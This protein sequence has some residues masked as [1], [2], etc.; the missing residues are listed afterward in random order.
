MES[1]YRPTCAEIS[2]DALEYNITQFRNHLPAGMKLLTCV[3]A[4]AYGHGAV[5]I[6]KQVTA[7]GV[8]YLAVA[9]LDEAL[10]LRRAGIET[11]VLIL[12]YTPPSGIAAAAEYGITLNL[13]SEEMLEAIQAYAQEHP[14]QSVKAHIKIDTGMGRV[15][16][17]FGQEAIAFIEHALQVPGLEIEGLFTHFASSD[18]ADKT[19]MMLQYKRFD[20]VVRHFKERHIEFPILHTGNSAA[21]IEHPECSYNM[22][23]VGIS[24]YGLYPSDEVDHTAIDLQ[25]V[26]SLKTKIAHLKTLPADSGISYGTIYVTQEDEAIATLPIGYADGYSRMLTNKV[27]VLIGGERVPVVGTICM[28]QCM[29][30]VTTVEG[31]GLGDEVVLIGAQGDKRI[32]A[33]EIAAGLGTINYEVTCMIANRVPRVYKKSGEVV[34]ISNPLL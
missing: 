20:E 13:F 10:Q 30:N 29:A 1:F 33:E 27:E 32:T 26:M 4:N 18:E 9:F 31:V 19:Y 14:G 24:L 23:R 16:V 28:D 17:Q 34:K 2:L 11:P 5:E 21:A 22:V 7:W 3:K 6:A 15:G 25:P 12:G 8:D